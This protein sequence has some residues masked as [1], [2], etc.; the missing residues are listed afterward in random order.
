MLVGQKLGPFLI[1]K[2]LGAGAMGAVYG[3]RYVK[4]GARVAIKVMMPGVAANEHSAA[5][6]KREAE[7][8]KQ[9]NHPNIVK[10][11]G[12][13]TSSGIRFYAMEYI[14]GEP[15]DQVLQRRGRFSWEVVVELGQQLCAALQHAHEQGVVHRDLKP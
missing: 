13:G 1:E 4:T 5:R 7:I 12:T 8:L 11:Y 10:L 15:L 14:D 3:G 2:E 6:F 9:F